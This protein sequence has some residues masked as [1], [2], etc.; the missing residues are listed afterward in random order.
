MK[1]KRAQIELIVLKGFAI[2][3]LLV[4]SFLVAETIFAKTPS[5]DSIKCSWDCSDAI[6]SDCV[7]S[8][9]YRDINLCEPN[10]KVCWTSNPKP[11]SKIQCIS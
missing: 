7:N 4:G 2:A 6:W 3:L 8:Y 10:K 9:S 11:S 5:G 1:Q